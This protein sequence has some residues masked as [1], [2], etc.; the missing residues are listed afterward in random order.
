[1]KYSVVDNLIKAQNKA[2]IY[3]EDP[4]GVAMKNFDEAALKFINKVNIHTSNYRDNPKEAVAASKN[5]ISKNIMDSMTHTKDILVPD[6]ILEGINKG[7]TLTKD[8]VK[9]KIISYSENPGEAVL[10]V[11]KTGDEMYKILNDSANNLAEK[12]GAFLSKEKWKNKL[13]NTDKP[14]INKDVEI[15]S[16]SEIRKPNH[17]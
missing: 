1:M 10:D 12:T 17:H 11:A 9:N 4:R 16:K 5:K 15:I 2:F 13:Q 6:V 14:F 7:L 3:T 8:K